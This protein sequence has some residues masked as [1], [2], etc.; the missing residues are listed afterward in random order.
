MSY[1]DILDEKDKNIVRIDKFID[2][3]RKN[4]KELD[5]YNQLVALLNKEKK[6][7]L[8]L[9]EKDSNDFTKELKDIGYQISLKILEIKNNKINVIDEISSEDKK[10]ILEPDK[11][12]DE[13]MHNI[14]K[15][16]YKN[17]KNIFSCLFDYKESNASRVR[18]FLEETFFNCDCKGSPQSKIIELLTSIKNNR[19]I[20]KNKK[21]KKIF[22]KEVEAEI[23]KEKFSDKFIKKKKEELL[24]NEAIKIKNRLLFN[25]LFEYYLTNF[26]E[27]KS[28]K[29][30]V[31]AL[32]KFHPLILSGI[33]LISMICY[34][35]YF[36][37]FVG[38]FPA[39]SGSDIFYFGGLL[40]FT[41][42]I[43]SI[44]AIL[45][46]FLYPEYY[47]TG[48]NEKL[49]LATAIPPMLIYTYLLYIS[50]IT[51]LYV[52]VSAYLLIFFLICLSFKFKEWFNKK[53]WL[54]ILLAIVTSIAGLTILIYS[55]PNEYR[56]VIK[57][58]LFL[59]SVMCF[60]IPLGFLF[61]MEGFYRIK[62]YKIILI[63][64]TI[65]IPPFFF[66][67]LTNYIAEQFGLSNINYKYIVIEKSA[68]GAI[69]DRIYKNDENLGK[70]KTYYGEDKISGTIKLYNIKAISTLGKFYYLEA[71]GCENNEK[72]R[73]E[74]D[75]SKII[76]RQ[77][78]E[79]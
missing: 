12:L 68:L 71:I 33:S 44:I 21:I 13:N 79:S 53:S 35:V 27:Q 5:K 29:D 25:K 57:N 66:I 69:P 8:K 62:E 50:S 38:Y 42:V 45:P 7:Y 41:I 30:H 49:L 55:T 20:L 31:N 18:E 23:A 37:L 54:Y 56:Y 10:Q 32:L 74:L 3:L 76:S 17:F 39:L 24:N 58:L 63:I 6:L 73:F 1:Q 65:A 36:G 75:S 4:F 67:T 16:L 14:K 78:Q 72:I 47:K 15:E 34:F 2:F 52:F 60:F 22:N 77:K 40:F 61:Y 64:F 48:K 19:E 43:I 9:G 46:M 70:C 11:L 26:Y 51:K 59:S 28:I